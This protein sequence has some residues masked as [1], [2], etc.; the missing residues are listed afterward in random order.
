MV[1]KNEPCSICEEY[2]E[3]VICDKDK[4]PVGEMKKENERLQALVDEMSGY[5]PTCIGCEGKTTLGERADKCVYLVDDTEYCAKRGIR[6]IANIMKKNE[7]LKAEIE[8]LKKAIKVQD[9]MIEQ[10]DY[11]IKSAKSEA[12]KEFAER[13]KAKCA[14]DRGFAVMSD[15]AIDNLVKEMTE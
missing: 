10:Q 3:G 15:D 7:A 2:I 11:K 14:F 1:N 5:F 6:N 9:I 8:R 4:C 12:I 13:L